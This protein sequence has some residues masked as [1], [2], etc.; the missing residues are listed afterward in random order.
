MLNI[1]V[2]TTTTDPN[3]TTTTTTTVPTFQVVKVAVDLTNRGDSDTLYLSLEGTPTAYT[4]GCVGYS[5]GMDW[6]SIEWDATLDDD[7]KATVAVD[8]TDIP[9]DVTS[10][11]AQIWWAGVGT[12][13]GEND[14][15]EYSFEAAADAIVYGDANNN[16]TVEVADAVLLLQGI[17]DPGN[18]LYALSDAGRKAADVD[19]SGAP[20][21]QDAVFIQQYKA[22]IIGTLPYVAE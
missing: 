4:N 15:V 13:I 1:P 3:A 7:G 16:G 10:A 14:I 6:Y 5:I 12:E 9:A 11:E 22:D 18:E 8:I 20:D 2:V 21:S 19:L 17:V